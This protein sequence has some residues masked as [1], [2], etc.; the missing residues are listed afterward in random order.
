MCYLIVSLII[1]SP[2]MTKVEILFNEIYSERSEVWD[3][4][5][6]LRKLDTKLNDAKYSNI[7][8][9]KF[10]CPD[11]MQGK[12]KEEGSCIGFMTRLDWS[13]L[14]NFCWSNELNNGELV[15]DFTKYILSYINAHNL[16]DLFG[17]TKSERLWAGYWNNG[18][19]DVHN[20]LDGLNFDEFSLLFKKYIKFMKKT[21][22]VKMDYLVLL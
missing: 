4:I 10:N 14:A 16:D 12:Y 18:R 20:L 8:F 9:N 21:Y 17:Y 2:I 15:H 19:Y 13:N 6:T 11:H 1:H 7:F 3:D 22:D 5:N